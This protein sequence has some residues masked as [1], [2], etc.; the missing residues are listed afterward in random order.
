MSSAAECNTNDS[1]HLKILSQEHSWPP[2]EV[3]GCTY[4]VPKA[5]RDYVCVAGVQ[6]FVLYDPGKN[7]HTQHSKS[8]QLNSA[9]YYCRRQHGVVQT[10][11]VCTRSDPGDDVTGAAFA[12]WLFLASAALSLPYNDP[13][14]TIRI[15][16]ITV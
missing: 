8:V 13:H 4:S 1:T 15:H 10:F 14:G 11:G 5:F 9:R 12:P 6:L 3:F 16:G 2:S 7:V